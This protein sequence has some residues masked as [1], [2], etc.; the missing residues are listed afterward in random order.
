MTGAAGV[1]GFLQRNRRAVSWALV[2]LWAVVIFL[3]SANT[4][5]D[6]TD[7]DGLV[8]RV[9]AMLVS[10]QVAWFG[11]GIDL[12]SPLAH[13]CEYALFGFLLQNALG[14]SLPVRRAVLLAVVI[15]SAYGVTDEF[16]QLFVPGRACDPV[17]WLV[18]TA[19][20][21]LGALVAHAALRRFQSQLNRQT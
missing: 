18:D 15:A 3:M 7:G 5:E 17:D 14:C 4:G 10:V 16:H 20:A 1:R 6:L 11:S 12:V 13:F 21:T 19:G 9:R 8:A 2:A